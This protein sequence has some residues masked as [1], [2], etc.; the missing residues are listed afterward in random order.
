MHLPLPDEVYSPERACMELAVVKPR[1]GLGLW[2]LAL[3]AQ[4]ADAYRIEPEQTQ[5]LINLHRFGGYDRG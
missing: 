5:L 2:L 4:A 3:G 1:I